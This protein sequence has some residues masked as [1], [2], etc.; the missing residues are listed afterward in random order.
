M[1]ETEELAAA[2]RRIDQL[3]A[4]LARRTELIDKRQYELDRVKGSH[5]YQFAHG[6]QKLVERFFPLYSRRR[7]WLKSAV[8][9][10]TA[11]A[12]WAWRKRK[13]KDGPPPEARHLLESIP[14]DEYVRWMAKHE[15]TVAD[16]QTQQSHKFAK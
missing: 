11:P 14:Q 1:S 9:I 2:Y 5:A 13:A 12:K 6:T 7:T 15:P 16:L 3:E 10:T 8:R 4:A